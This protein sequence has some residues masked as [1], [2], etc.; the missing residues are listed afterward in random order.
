M[1]GSQY[2]EG[3]GG[4]KGHAYQASLYEN[5]LSSLLRIC[6]VYQGA[7]ATCCCTECSARKLSTCVGFTQ[8][9]SPICIQTWLVWSSRYSDST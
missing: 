9:N 8:S 2:V 4:D 1:T 7:I 5:L 6:S 3:E